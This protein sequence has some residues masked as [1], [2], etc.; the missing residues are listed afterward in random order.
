MRSMTSNSGWG[1]TPRQSIEAECGRRGRDA[2]VIGCVA[3]VHGQNVDAGLL[4]ALG[5]PGARKFLSGPARADD[6]WLRVWGARALLWV[7]SDEA[8]GAVRIALRDES[9]R[10]R[11]VALK[12]VARHRLDDLLEYVGGLQDDDV[13]RVRAAAGRALIALTEAGPGPES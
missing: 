7:W 12:V 1:L 6:Y 13:P 11:E 9:W 4:L 10:V 8:L 3:L 2:V 5:G